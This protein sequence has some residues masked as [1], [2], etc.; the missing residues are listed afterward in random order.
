MVTIELSCIFLPDRKKLQHDDFE[1]S[2]SDASDLNCISH[3]K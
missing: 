3:L 2:A 1:S